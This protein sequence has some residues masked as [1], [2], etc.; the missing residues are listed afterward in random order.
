MFTIAT[1]AFFLGVI[2]SAHCIGMC[3]GIATLVLTSASNSKW[4]ALLWYQAGRVSVYVLLGT[5]AGLFTAT[6]GWTSSLIGAQHILSIIAGMIV[7]LMGLHVAGWI[8]DPL[9]S[10]TPLWAKLTRFQTILRGS[11]LGSNR[12]RSLKI[13]I[14][15]GLLPCGMVYA[16]LAM[17]VVAGDVASA[18]LTMFAFGMGTVPA[19]L[20]APALLRMLIVRWRQHAV[21]IV[22][23]IMVGV[24][25]VTLVRGLELK[26][27]P[28]H[29]HG[30]FAH[31]EYSLL[32]DKKAD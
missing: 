15:N 14:S 26:M 28:G 24:G 19:M 9:K 31:I 3:G 7:V 16:A 29:S 12:W 4:R 32:E 27:A 5:A 21:N 17:A 25:V 23:V 20:C 2:G 22:A 18:T 1:T 30:E 11:N 6:V 13:G 8:P 10:F